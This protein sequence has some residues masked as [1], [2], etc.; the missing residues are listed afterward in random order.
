M[1]WREV[2]KKFNIVSLKR[3]GVGRFAMAGK[4][5]KLYDMVFGFM[6]VRKFEANSMVGCTTIIRGGSLIFVSDLNQCD[7][8][9]RIYCFYCCKIDLS[10]GA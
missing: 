2:Q 10:G 1:K 4:F 5:S 7:D 3:Y 8:N 6:V 9:K